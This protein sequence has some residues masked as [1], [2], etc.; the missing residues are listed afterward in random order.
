MKNLK[1][2]I[3]L[4]ISLSFLIIACEKQE[5]EEEITPYYNFTEQ[6]LTRVIIPTLNDTIIFKNQNEDKLKLVVTE[7]LNEKARHFSPGLWGNLLYYYD[8]HSVATDYD[9]DKTAMTIE[10]KIYSDV[11]TIESVVSDSVL[12]RWG[13][14]D[15]YKKVNILYYDELNGLIGF[16]DIE[17]NNWRINR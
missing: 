9:S 15:Y 1:S 6:D 14:L 10:N 7:V 13:G 5:I 2:K 16:D 12:D 8:G 17:G 4:G 3:L 11:F